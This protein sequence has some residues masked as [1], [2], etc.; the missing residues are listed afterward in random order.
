MTK[1]KKDLIGLQ[2][3][4]VNFAD[5]ETEA[6]VEIICRAISCERKIKQPVSLPQAEILA[7]ELWIKKAKKSLVKLGDLAFNADHE[8]FWGNLPTD[9]D[10]Y[11]FAEPGE[12]KVFISR[13]LRRQCPKI[14][15]ARLHCSEQNF[16]ATVWKSSMKICFSTVN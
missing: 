5:D 11:H 15:S 6:K 3:E 7:F 9:E 13:C 2:V 10:L 12:K 16:S 1:L 8:R 14:I 4:T